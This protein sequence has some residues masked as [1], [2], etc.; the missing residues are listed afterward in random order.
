[1]NTTGSTWEEELAKLVEA[2]DLEGL[3]KFSQQVPEGDISA[4]RDEVMESGF[5]ALYS[6]ISYDQMCGKLGEGGL[7]LL[8]DVVTEAETFHGSPLR[9]L[10]AEVLNY[11]LDEVKDTDVGRAKEFALRAIDELSF[12]IPADNDALLF[13]ANVY[14]QLAQLDAVD[15][16][17]YWQLAVEDLKTTGGFNV[18]ILYHPW[19][20]GIDGMHEAQLQTYA[21]FNH[22][23]NQELIVNPDRLWSVLDDSVRMHEYHQ[24]PELKKQL[25]VWLQMAI[26]WKMYDAP[27]MLLRSAGLLLHKQGKSQ[28]RAD[29]FAKAIECFELFIKKNPAH[30][31][32]VNYMANVLEDWAELSETQGNSGNDYLAKAWEVY[33][34]HEEV[35][36][37]NF[38]PLLHYAEFLERL[39]FNNKITKRPTEEKI[40]AL[41]VEA[42][43]MGNGYYSGPGMIQARMAISND[44][45]DTAIHHLCRL[46]LRHELCIDNLIK[47][48]RQ[49]LTDKAPQAVVAFLDQALLFMEEV[50]KGYYYHPAFSMED[51]NQLSRSETADA[52]QQRMAGIRNRRALE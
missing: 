51:L 5:M 9:K 38:S 28:Q 45:A 12:E 29:Y 49:S 48:L 47:N 39:Y 6:Y 1:M 14:H 15:A 44:D 25:S 52:W 31:M 16:L 36:R 7:D 43:V 42:E 13:R 23:L 21:E 17:H 10:R 26:S 18:W 34:K 11:R 3:I 33:Q 32:E 4:W 19:P 24:N 40:L 37:I 8:D 2:Y 46:L 30:A 50:N 22:R 20:Q 27:V 41:A 35:V